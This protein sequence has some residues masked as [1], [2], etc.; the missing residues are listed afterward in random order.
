M[1]ENLK[2]Q[3]IELERLSINISDLIKDNK[4]E[5]IIELDLRRQNIIKSINIEHAKDFKNEL[6]GIFENNNKQI[7]SIEDDILQLKKKSKKSLKCFKAYK[8]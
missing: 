6:I 3:L 1:F 2:D 4:Y 8:N 5:N 7:K